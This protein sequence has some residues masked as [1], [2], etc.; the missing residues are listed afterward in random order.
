VLLYSLVGDWL[1]VTV[2]KNQLKLVLNK[3]EEV[4]LELLRLRA[5]L[6]PEEELSGGKMGKLEEARKEIREGRGINLED[7]IKE[8][9]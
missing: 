7:L 9:G 6:L 5:M 4:K 8:L 3:L 1:S 2:S